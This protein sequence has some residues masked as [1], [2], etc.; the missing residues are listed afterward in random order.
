MKIST[1]TIDTQI[2]SKMNDAVFDLEHIVLGPNRYDYTNSKST[3][4][5]SFNRILTRIFILTIN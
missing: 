5:Q 2:A 1:S 3:E 4:L